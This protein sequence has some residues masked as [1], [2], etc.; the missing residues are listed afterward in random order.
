MK[1]QKNCLKKYIEK[2]TPSSNVYYEPHAESAASRLGTLQE[3]GAQYHRLVIPILNRPEHNK[4]TLY[5]NGQLSVEPSE[6]GE[7]VYICRICQIGSEFSNIYTLPEFVSHMKTHTPK[8]IQCRSE[9]DAWANYEAHLPFCPYMYGKKERS[10]EFQKR[11][12]YAPYDENLDDADKV[13]LF[14]KASTTAG[15]FSGGNQSGKR[16]K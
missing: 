6:I 4:F 2:Y 16:G 12:K 13:S 1:L 3:V 15:V 7:T 10:Y 8:C 14:G 5:P 11:E 9:F